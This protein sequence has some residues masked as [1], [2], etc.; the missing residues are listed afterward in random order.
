M[1]PTQTAASDRQERYIA[2]LWR[3]L[4]ATPYATDAD[5]FLA[6]AGIN[7]DTPNRRIAVQA[8]ELESAAAGKLIS[9]LL[10]LRAVADAADRAALAAD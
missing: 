9:V 2:A 7:L 10:R 8:A 4:E 3:E 6:G 5:S 1:Q